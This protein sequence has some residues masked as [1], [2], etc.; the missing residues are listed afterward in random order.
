MNNI[1]VFFMILSFYD[2]GKDGIT[3]I[4]YDPKFDHHPNHA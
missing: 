2:D 1:Q 3:G 4:T